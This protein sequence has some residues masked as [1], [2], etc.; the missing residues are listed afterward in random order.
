MYYI[1]LSLEVSFFSLLILSI[2]KTLGE[3]AYNTAY[4]SANENIG[5]DLR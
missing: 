3:D 1:F 4:L 5:Q 2:I